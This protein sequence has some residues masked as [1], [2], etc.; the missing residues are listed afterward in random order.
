MKK[1]LFIGLLIASVNSYSQSVSQSNAEPGD[2]VKVILGITHND[3]IA[4]NALRN[5]INSMNGAKVV[6]YCSNHAVFML[7]LDNGAYADSNDFLTK[8]KK[9]AP[10]YERLVSIKEGDFDSFVKVCQPANSTDAK[11]LKNLVTN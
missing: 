9:Q 10:E 8:L 3:E 7:M 1:L 11:N 5:T 2:V 6:S 4:G